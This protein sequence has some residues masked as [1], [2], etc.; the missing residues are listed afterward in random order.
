[1]EQKK[2]IEQND[3]IA[4]ECP[5]CHQQHMIKYDPD[6]TPTEEQAL[7]AMACDC[8]GSWIVRKEN[9]IKALIQDDLE[10]ADAVTAVIDAVK[11]MRYGY[12]DRMTI[13]KGKYTYTIS[14]NAEN[15]LKFKRQESKK[16]EM[17]L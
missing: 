10:E 2:Q 6:L 17:T 13:K 14:L 11:M 5:Y 4:L 8:P 15:V 12:F 7:A 9:R 3:L 16:Q 1:M